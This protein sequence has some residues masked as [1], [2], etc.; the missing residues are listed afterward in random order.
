[1]QIKH[2]AILEHAD[3]NM[4]RAWTAGPDH[5]CY[6]IAQGPV[7]SEIYNLCVYQPLH[8]LD[9]ITAIESHLAGMIVETAWPE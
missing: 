8:T 5:G 9:R 2:Y 6:L 3:M 4:I 1:M 7:G